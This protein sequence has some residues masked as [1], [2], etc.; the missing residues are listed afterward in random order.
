MTHKADR[1][2]MVDVMG[3]G[4]MAFDYAFG[5]VARD[6]FSPRDRSMVTLAILG[7]T[8]C[9]EE[10][11][12][13]TRIALNHGCT[14]DEV[15]EIFVHMT[16][17]S[18][19]LALSPPRIRYAQSLRASMRRKRSSRTDGLTT[20]RPD[21][22]GHGAARGIGL[23]TARM[24]MSEGAN[25]ALLVDIDA[26]ACEEAADALNAT[27]TSGRAL[28][29]PMDITAEQAVSDAFATTKRAG[30]GDNTHPLR[31]YPR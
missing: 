1:Q 21:S 13:H 29:I 27:S 3:V 8:H 11:Q 14:R 26:D 31:R 24:L 25:V 12:I 22:A 30:C 4:E 5:E 23:A 16:G 28:A 9:L 15:E 20:E 6:A 17:Y 10:L 18:G 7:I 19:F 2:A